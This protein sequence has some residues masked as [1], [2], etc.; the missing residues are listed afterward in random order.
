MDPNL[1]FEELLTGVSFA[2]AGSGF[3][4]LT[5]L[6][7]GVFPIPKQMEYF[8]ECKKRLE[9]VIGKQRT[10]E[11]IKKAVFFISAGTNDFV[12]NYFTIPIRRRSYTTL[13][14]HHFLMQHI[15]Q[16]I[17]D[18]WSE[19][20]RN[21]AVAGLPPMGCLPVVITINSENAFLQRECIEKFSSAARDYNLILQNELH[22]MQ[23]NLSN[24]RAK[25]TYI[26][27]YGPLAY[28]IQGQGKFGF[29]KVDCGCCGS[30]Y[31]E[32]SFLC[33]GNSYVCSN[34]SKYVFFDSIHPTE[35]AYYTMFKASRATIDHIIN[36]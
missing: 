1:S 24:S 14:Y 6:I 16:F 27:T 31:I 35:M 9:S 29:D 7:S 17:Q 18:L 22:F 5:P 20:A 15:K 19:G 28:M 25:L 33:N 8:R 23:T 10:E 12:V 30:G 21:I 11:H 34:A 32:A 3:D 13:S 4:P 26:D 36:H 2:S